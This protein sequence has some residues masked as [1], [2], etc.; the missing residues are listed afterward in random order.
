MMGEKKLISLPIY[1][2]DQAALPKGTGSACTSDA[3]CSGQIC[4]QGQCLAGRRFEPAEI[5]TLTK[6]CIAGLDLNDNKLDDASENPGDTPDPAS[7]FKPLLAVGYFVE[8]HR[9]Y[10]QA[11]YDN[12]G[13]KIAVYHIHERPRNKAV[14]QQGLA[15]NCQQQA[16]A[17]QPD[18]WKFCK[19]KDNQQCADPNDPTKRKPGLSNCWLKDTQ[20]LLPSLFACV[21]FDNNQDKTKVEG[22]FH[23]ENHGFSN[24]YNRAVC[25]FQAKI[26]ENDPTQRDLA[27]SCTADDGTRK[28][29]P[30]KQEVG[31]ACVSFKA[32]N[33]TA[34]YLGG[35]VDEKAEKACGETKDNETVVYLKHETNS[36]GLVRAYAACGQSNGK[37]ECDKARRVCSSG[38]WL[39]C[40][41]CD[42]CPQTTT[43]QQAACPNGVWPT[44][45]CKRLKGPTNEI[46]DG[47]DNNC[48]G[49]IDEGLATTRYYKDKDNDTYGDPFD[50]VDKCPAQKPNGYVAIAGDCDDT[51][52]KVNPLAAEICDGKDNNCNGQIDENQALIKY[53]KDDDGDGFGANSISPAH[54][55]CVMT[56]DTSKICTGQNTCI[57][58]TYTSPSGQSRTYKTTNTDCCDT[59]ANAKPGQTTFFTA[60]NACGSWDYNCDGN[61]TTDTS[62]TLCACATTVPYSETTKAW[63]RMNTSQS[64]KYCEWDWDV[65][66]TTNGTATST[67]ATNKC[68]LDKTHVYKYTSDFSKTCNK[69]C[70]VV[71]DD[72]YE[73]NCNND[74]ND[75]FTPS[76]ADGTTPLFAMAASQFGVATTCH[77]MQDGTTPTCGSVTSTINKSTADTRPTYEAYDKDVCSGSKTK[78]TVTWRDYC[79]YN[80]TVYYNTSYSYF[81]ITSIN[82]GTV[83][84]CR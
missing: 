29:D 71:G 43:G 41:K 42:N 67:N 17:F 36:Y 12:N 50:F 64:N 61:T 69:T 48:D 14:G 33:T 70:A 65:E 10:Y 78:C 52:D 72:S 24:H 26:N 5:N 81:K 4:Y 38:T 57:S 49:Q 28:P 25:N 11:D 23:P 37:G 9:G 27:F 82:A 84:G 15:L 19:L 16:D 66:K 58:L 45:S 56:G 63:C 22:Y 32:Y 59:D 74:I 79:R 6:G 53:Y 3:D 55:G 73:V 8:L 60:K 35:C 7:E 13:T 68:Q 77:F 46:C 30:T 80:H 54:T 39:D 2:K 44:D 75:S 1:T 83:V 34:D 51:S 76:A 20:R 47:L 40:D 62:L 18:Y 31:W 21:V